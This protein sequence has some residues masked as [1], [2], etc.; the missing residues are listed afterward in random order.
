MTLRRTT[1]A[2]GYE[3]SAQIVRRR[4]LLPVARS[5]SMFLAE[6]DHKGAAR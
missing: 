4:L 6:R 2:E 3:K 1:T 5:R